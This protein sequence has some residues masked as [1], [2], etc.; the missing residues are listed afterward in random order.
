MSP[1]CTDRD[2]LAIEPSV[3]LAGDAVTQHRAAGADGQLA[4]TTFTSLSADFLAAGI[5]PGMV[6]CTTTTIPEEGLAWEIVS[7]DAAT[8]LTVSVLRPGADD[9]AIPGPD[10]DG[11]TYHIR[12]CA[13]QIAA[14]SAGLGETLRQL[15]EVAGISEADFADSAQLVRVTALGVLAGVFRAR[16]EAARP[17]DANWIKADHYEAEFRRARNELR[18]AVDADGDG[19]AEQ[20]RTLGNIRLRRA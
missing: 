14:V 16:C 20:T 11:L 1:F 6:L 8:A 18:L 7:A 17:N 12:T 13:A 3:F 10:A 4:G 2:I 19:F 5:E 9:P 15:A